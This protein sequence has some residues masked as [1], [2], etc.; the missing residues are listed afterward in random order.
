MLPQNSPFA[1]DGTRRRGNQPEDYGFPVVSPESRTPYSDATHTKPADRVKRPM[2]AFMV[3]SQIQR[4]RLTETDP[5]L[6]NAEIS[7]RLGKVWKTLADVE[8]QP[9]IEEAERLRVFHSKEYPDYKYRPRKK[10]AT[11]ASAKKKGLQKRKAAEKRGGRS[12]YARHTADVE[13]A[14]EVKRRTPPSANTSKA[15]KHGFRSRRL[16]SLTDCKVANSVASGPEDCLSPTTPESLY[17]LDS[18]LGS[19]GL[20]SKGLGSRADPLGGSSASFSSSEST[21]SSASSCAIDRPLIEGIPSEGLFFS[22]EELDG[23]ART[24]MWSCDW[25]VDRDR[26]LCQDA[27]SSWFNYPETDYSTPEVTEIL[28]NSDWLETNLGFDI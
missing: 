6:H 22:L 20:G 2:N 25:N 11:L 5:K 13:R 3:W 26:D 18:D 8:R 23:Y 1:D 7:K 12:H 19:K 17:P 21:F 9:F 28:G 15:L 10:A 4:R 24:G 16:L 27:L 14:T